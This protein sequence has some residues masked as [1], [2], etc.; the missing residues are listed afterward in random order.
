MGAQPLSRRALRRAIRHTGKPVMLGHTYGTN[1]H[2]L[3][4][5]DHQHLG[6]DTRSSDTTPA[7]PVVHTAR[8]RLIWPEDTVTEPDMRHA[9][10]AWMLHPREIIAELTGE[11]M[12]EVIA[13]ESM[14]VARAA[15]S[16]LVT[17]PAPAAETTFCEDVPV[18]AEID[19]QRIELCHVTINR[20]DLTDDVT[21]ADLIAR[22]LMRTA[23]AADTEPT[24]EHAIMMFG[25]G[26]HVRADGIEQVYPLADWLHHRV[27]N[28]TPVY[29]RRVVVVEDWTKVTNP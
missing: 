12:D 26:M 14:R 27:Q 8:C 25:G 1:T 4:T 22:D 29:R 6:W 2:H 16:E 19:G 24:I 10:L 9:D 28:G 21:V 7:D 3:V 18:F 23:R 15:D 11:T 13:R 17:R 20:A 5:V